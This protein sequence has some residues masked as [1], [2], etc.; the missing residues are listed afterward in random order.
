[1]QTVIK[2][3]GAV[4]QDR[5]LL[6]A[7]FTEFSDLPA[8]TVLVHGGGAR[9]S[10]LSRRLGIEPRFV[11]GIRMTGDDEMEIVEAVLAGE[12]NGEVVRAANKA[13]LRALGVSG[14]DGIT[15][16]GQ[17]I[18]DSRTASVSTVDLSAIRYLWSGNYLPILAPVGTEDDGDPVNIN[19]DESA[20]AIAEQLSRTA[21]TRLCYLSDV[22]GVLDREGRRIERIAVDRIETL[23]TDGTI[24]GGMVAKVRS[25]GAAVTAGLDSVTI[26]AWNATGDLVALLNGV[27]GTRIIGA[28]QEEP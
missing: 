16:R 20:R 3:G 27:H 11:D 14:A 10:A 25:A 5:K 21:P 17:R 19:A 22:P 6:T 24:T 1:M 12:V 7:F 9:V 13:G 28:S 2:I 18:G 4:T 26:G 8:T 23:V 15:L